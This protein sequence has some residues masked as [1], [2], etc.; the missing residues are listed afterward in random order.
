M[1][2][3][4]EE[5]QKISPH[6]LQNWLK[7]DHHPPLLI[8]VRED[9][10]LDIAPFP[11]K[12]VHMPLSKTSIWMQSLPSYLS[13]DKPIVVICHAGIRSWN[14]GLWLIEQQWENEIWNLEGGIDSWSVNV[15]SSVPRY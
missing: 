13:K 6:E 9:E 11:H 10:E 15:D 7:S 12:V 5:P 2:S 3:I 14:F 4:Q 1:L 8:D